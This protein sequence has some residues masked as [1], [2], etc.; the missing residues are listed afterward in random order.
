MNEFEWFQEACR[1]TA[2]RDLTSRDAH[3][4]W[5]LGLAGESGEYCEL[6]KKAVFH[7]KPY[8]TED[9]KKEL[10]DILYYLAAAATENGLSLLDI[11]RTNVD[12]LKERYPE[13]FQEGGGNRNNDSEDDG[14]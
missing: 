6:V 3:L 2:N 14:N 13:G 7:G 11:A 9:A 12:K 5:A 1:R 10:G 8:K 4:N